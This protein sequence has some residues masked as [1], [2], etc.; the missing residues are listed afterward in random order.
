M[1]RRPRTALLTLTLL[2]AACV[3]DGNGP[4]TGGLPVV[5]EVP[6]PENYGIHDTYVRDGLAFVLAWN[7]GVLIYDVGNGIR[8]G[9]PENPVLVSSVATAGGQAHNGWWFHNPTS[10]EW[11][12]FF[13]GQ[14]GPASIGSSSS[15]D[16]HVLDVS[17][18]FNPVEVAFFHLD[19]AGPHNFWMDESAEI[20]Y[21][22]YYNAGV[23]ALDVSGTLTGD[24]A[25]REL[26]RLQP[27]GP[28]NTYT[29]SV[30]LSGGALYAI[31]MLSGLW[32]LTPDSTL[33]PVAG[34]NN[35]A[36]RFSSD[37]WVHGNHAYTGTWGWFQRNGN[38][39]NAAKV[40]RLDSGPAPVLVDS[41]IVGNVSAV[42]DVQVSEDGKLLV[43]S[44]E[45]GAAGGLFVYGLT[46]P[47]RPALVGSHR[48]STG[49]HTVTLSTIAGRLYAFGA[50]NPGGA[51]LMIFDLTELIQ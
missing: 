29:W 19:G 47:G 30:Q 26:A 45:G 24:L 28:G 14:E 18:L 38:P 31:D 12:Y 48:V 16:I 51:A 6:I 8:N 37:L 27:G 46:D 34:G 11:R 3:D 42:S 36:D 17:D 50:R 44:T 20:L 22:A 35:V 9:T 39:G 10:G 23:V 43:L 7:T 40:W 5:R 2:S 1:D 33:A 41:V 32:C 4:G 21:A 25:A 13:V 49:L 15:G